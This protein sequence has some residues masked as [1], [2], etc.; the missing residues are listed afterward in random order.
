[1]LE[2]NRA[3]VVEDAVEDERER[4]ASG[5]EPGQLCLAPLDRLVPEIAAVDLD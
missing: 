4:L 5:Q 1:V 3:R 2:H